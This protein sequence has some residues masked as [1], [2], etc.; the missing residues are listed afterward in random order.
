MIQKIFQE[1][2]YVYIYTKYIARYTLIYASGYIYTIC[3][4]ELYI[5]RIMDF[6]YKFYRLFKASFT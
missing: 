3:D 6:C 1:L 4:I 2:K 5:Y